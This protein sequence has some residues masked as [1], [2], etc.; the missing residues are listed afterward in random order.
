MA[1]Y[2][3][4]VK[5]IALSTPI[6]VLLSFP[7]SFGI[8][9]SV[10][11]IACLGDKG[12]ATRALMNGIRQMAILM[13]PFIFG[14]LAATILTVNGERTNWVTNVVLLRTYLLAGVLLFALLPGVKGAIN[15][16]VAGENKGVRQIGL[17]F[18]LAWAFLYLSLGAQFFAYL[19]PPV[20]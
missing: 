20:G 5:L 19:L 17:W 4:L 16:L 10:H 3:A 18:G 7:L 9:E 14:T 6:M 1:I 13:L 11:C 12:T 2:D 8:M 15:S